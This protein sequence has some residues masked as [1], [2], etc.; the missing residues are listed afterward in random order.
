M[1]IIKKIYFRRKLSLK[2]YP[3]KKIIM[4]KILCLLMIGVALVAFS[5]TTVKTCDCTEKITGWQETV[6]IK[7]GH[8]TAFSNCK[9]LQKALNEEAIAEGYEQNW[10]C[11]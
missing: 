2:I 4:K 5:C 8:E 6:P 3:L 1:L 10:S 11:K 7:A 9:Q